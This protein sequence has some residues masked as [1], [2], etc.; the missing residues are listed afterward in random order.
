MQARSQRQLDSGLYVDMA[1]VEAFL[2]LAEELHFGRAAERLHVSQPRVSRLI[3]ALER[4]AG[5]RLFDRTSRKVTLTPLGQQFQA[6]LR[7]GHEQMRAALDHARRSARK[8]TGMLRVGCLITTAGPALTRLIDEFSAR[9]PDCQLGLHTVNTKDPYAPLRH[10]DIDVLVSYLVVDE[11]DLTAGP[12]LDYRDR[13]LHVGRRHRLAANESVLVE[14]LGDEEVHQNAP[15]FP[16]TLY[17]AIAPPATPSGRPIRRTY[18]WTDDE[19]VLTAVAR[20]RIIH[21]SMAG[22]PLTI[23][24]DIVQIPIRDLPPMPVGLIWRHA[25]ENARI[26]ALAAAARA[27]KPVHCTPDEAAA[28]RESQ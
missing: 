13:V 24:P 4:Q 2:A 14:D 20:G 28:D 18:P 1:Q 5:G 3:A 25:H 15:S 19:D 9:C 26:R 8:I 17:N 6:E 11:P 27:T 21:P 12:V 7:P 16:D 23:R 22:I 10:G